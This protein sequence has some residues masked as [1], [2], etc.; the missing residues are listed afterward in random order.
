MLRRQYGGGLILWRP[1]RF[2]GGG[3][4]GPANVEFVRGTERMML[5]EGAKQSGVTLAYS[6]DEL[7]A[8]TD[9]DYWWLFAR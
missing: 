5:S 6:R 2:I 3:A 9:G 8:I 7:I 1:A 4:G